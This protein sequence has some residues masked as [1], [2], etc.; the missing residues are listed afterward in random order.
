M[1]GTGFPA[2]TR[3]ALDSGLGALVEL[4][5]TAQADYLRA[6]GQAIQT[7]GTVMIKDEAGRTHRNEGCTV[8]NQAR[9]VM[10][11]VCYRAWTVPRNPGHRVTPASRVDENAPP[12]VESRRRG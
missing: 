12:I 10:L 7:Q 3:G 9:T 8:L 2:S 6:R 5:A 1:G 4:Y 11:R